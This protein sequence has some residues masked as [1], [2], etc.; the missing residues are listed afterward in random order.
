MFL[1]YVCFIWSGLILSNIIEGSQEKIGNE[2]K[3]AYYTIIVVKTNGEIPS[4][5]K[6]R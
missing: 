3:W 5:G 4:R 6:G 2:K 1:Y